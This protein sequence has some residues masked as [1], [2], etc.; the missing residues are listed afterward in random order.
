[1]P[2]V[3]I[4]P[5]I[6]ACSAFI[7]LKVLS[8]TWILSWEVS[9]WAIRFFTRHIQ[10]WNYVI[11]V[12]VIWWKW[13]L[14]GVKSLEIYLSV[15]LVGFHAAWWYSL[16][17]LEKKETKRLK[18]TNYQIILFFPRYEFIYTYYQPYDTLSSYKGMHNSDKYFS[19]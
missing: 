4:T 15:R 9:T 1:M 12:C 10:S 14:Y 8:L 2:F 19:A 6:V 16:K 3:I 11:G 13:T 7:Q 17:D 5:H 18:S